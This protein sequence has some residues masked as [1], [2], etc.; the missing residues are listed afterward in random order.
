MFSQAIN[1]RVLLYKVLKAFPR[2]VRLSVKTGD[3]QNFFCDHFHPEPKPALT[4]F[5]FISFVCEY[6]SA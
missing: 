2:N 1:R 5:D 4:I 6:R 3:Y